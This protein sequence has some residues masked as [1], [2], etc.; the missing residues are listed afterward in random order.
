[1]TFAP[2]APAR[3]ASGQTKPTIS[4]ARS[5]RSLSSRASAIDALLTPTS[6]SRSRGATRREIHSKLRRQLVT[7]TATKSPEVTNTPRR[8][9][10][11]RREQVEKRQNHGGGAERLQHADQ[12]LRAVREHAELVQVAVIEA[13]L[14]DD[15]HEQHCA[16]SAR[17]P[18]SPRRGADRRRPRW[19][20]RSGRFRSQSAWSSATSGAASI[21]ST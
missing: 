10:Q 13:Q 8:D 19:R 18:A 17:R 6:S 1:M 16:G 2:R 9:D 20:P 3:S 12:Q 15:D 4:I 7:P 14:T 11:A 21:C 5:V